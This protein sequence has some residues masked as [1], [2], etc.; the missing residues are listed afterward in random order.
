VF[1]NDGNSPPKK[2]LIKSLI[3]ILKISK[4][5]DNMFIIISKI[6]QKVLNKFEIVMLG[7]FISLRLQLL[8]LL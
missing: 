1:A 2:H 8:K 3:F 4:K 5:V 6:V 7:M